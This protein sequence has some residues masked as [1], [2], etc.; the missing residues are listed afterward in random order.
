M[1]RQLDQEVTEAL[2]QMRD[3]IEAWRN[4][5][6]HRSMN[7]CKVGATFADLAKVDELFQKWEHSST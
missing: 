5:K 3:E 4:G 6:N 7:K 2:T 1:N